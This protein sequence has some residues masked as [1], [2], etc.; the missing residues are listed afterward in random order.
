MEITRIGF[1][2]IFSAVLQCSPQLDEGVS[3]L[4]QEEWVSIPVAPGGQPIIVPVTLAGKSLSFLLAT[5][6]S[7][8][9][10]DVSLRPILGDSTATLPVTGFGTTTARANIVKTPSFLV[11]GHEVRPAAEDVSGVLDLSSICRIVEQDIHGILGP[12]FFR[13]R[14][15]Q[16]DFDQGM[17]RLSHR[18]VNTESLGRPWPL[19]LDG[20]GRL[21]VD[22]LRIGG[23]TE[24]FQI[25]TGS[26]FSILV[27]DWLFSS[28]RAEGKLREFP[29]FTTLTPEGSLISSGGLLSQVSWGEFSQRDVRVTKGDSNALG[30]QYLSR[31]VVTVDATGGQLFLRPGKNINRSDSIDVAGFETEKSGGAVVV[32]AVRDHSPAGEAGVLVGDSVTSINGVTCRDMRL[33]EFAW[34][35]D[36]GKGSRMTLTLERSGTSIEVSFDVPLSMPPELF[37]SESRKAPSADKSDVGKKSE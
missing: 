12:S 15:I 28:L 2:V 34:R 29:T 18:H 7:H 24:S 3:S 35:V 36:E 6:S 25:C 13:D 32:T 37:S 16:F 23:R 1:L 5:Q 9:A 4:K 17:V 10:F 26:N 20:L 22:N 30:L 19:R 21:W 31:F 8:H 33:L 14:L 11:G 27:H